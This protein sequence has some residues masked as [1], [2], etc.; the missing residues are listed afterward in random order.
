MGVLWGWNRL[1]GRGRDRGGGRGLLGD[2][3]LFQF[4]PPLCSV[5]V[6]LGATRTPHFP[7]LGPSLSSFLGPC[8]SYP[9]PSRQRLPWSINFRSVLVLVLALLLLQ[10]CIQKLT[11]CYSG[12]ALAPAPAPPVPTGAPPPVVSQHQWGVPLRKASPEV[13]RRSWGWGRGWEC[14]SS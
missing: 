13:P 7:S 8:F 14:F 11:T 2:L 12:C 1:G 6:S 4:F 3:A 9:S 5:L 10:N